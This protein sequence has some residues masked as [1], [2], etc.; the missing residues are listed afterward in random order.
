MMKGRRGGGEPGEGNMKMLIT[1]VKVR[2]WVVAITIGFYY[3]PLKPCYE[4]KPQSR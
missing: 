2:T 1:I 4:T 3:N